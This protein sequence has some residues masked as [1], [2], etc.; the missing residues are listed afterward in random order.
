[1]DAQL[2]AGGKGVS[3]GAVMADAWDR[4]KAAVGEPSGNICLHDPLGEI[5]RPCL[6]GSLGPGKVEAAGVGRPQLL[7]CPRDPVALVFI[8]L[9]LTDLET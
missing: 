8:R 5:G 9:I 7:L 3:H 4:Q 2:P 1:M 6:A